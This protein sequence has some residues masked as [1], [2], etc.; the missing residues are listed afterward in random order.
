[1]KRRYAEITGWG[2][3]APPRVVP[4]EAFVTMGLDTTDEW[5]RQRTGIEERHHADPPT[6]PA[7]LAYESSTRALE[8]AGLEASD[9]DAIV[10]ASLS[11]QHDFP[12]VSAFLQNLLGVGGWRDRDAFRKTRGA[13]SSRR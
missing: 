12:G 9:L 10:V 7:E 6:G 5:I 8:A 2:M 3:Y 1:M 13:S 4:N 11:P